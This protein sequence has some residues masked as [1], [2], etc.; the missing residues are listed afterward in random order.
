MGV[1]MALSFACVGMA[2][3]ET[4]VRCP[5]GGAPFTIEEEIRWW[6]LTWQMATAFQPIISGA[7]IP[8]S[9]LPPIS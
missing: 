5:R 4:T 7:E 6:D 1:V 3:K 8:G 2:R 9:F